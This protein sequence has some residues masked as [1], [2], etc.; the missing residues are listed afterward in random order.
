[1]TKRSRQVLDEVVWQTSKQIA[2]AVADCSSSGEL[3]QVLM[4]TVNKVVGADIASIMTAAPGQRWS[5]V[6]QIGDADGNRFVEQN[7]WRYSGEMSSSE[8]RGLSGKFVLASNVF[9]A[10]RRK[11]LSIF[12]EFLA[13]RRLNNVVV[14]HFVAEGRVWGIGLSRT[15]PSFSARALARLNA[16]LPYLRAALRAGWW[17]PAEP[18]VSSRNGEQRN[19]SAAA[20]DPWGLTP[21]QERTM[22]LVVRGLTNKEVASLLGTSANTVRNTLVEVFRKVGVSRR[23]ELAF[24]TSN[25]AACEDRSHHRGA[26]TEQR[27]YIST[28]E[29]MTAARL[30]V[31]ACDTPS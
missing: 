31:P 20:G 6:G 28:V 25:A 23:S 29:T 3:G 24:I 27:A 30:V 2:F 10:S 21:M 1:M 4:Q 26:A 14:A 15:S 7:Y 9:E 17:L 22:N 16:L 8:V 18:E 13:P 19:L 11:Q 5:T 12:R